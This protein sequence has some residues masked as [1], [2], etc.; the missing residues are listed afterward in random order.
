MPRTNKPPVPIPEGAVLSWTRGSSTDAD[1]QA[2]IDVLDGRV[3][4]RITYL[5]GGHNGIDVIE[6]ELQPCGER[7]WRVPFLDVVIENGRPMSRVQKIEILAPSQEPW[8]AGWAAGEIFKDGD[9]SP[10]LVIRRRLH[11][12][13]GNP[14]GFSNALKLMLRLQPLPEGDPRMDVELTWRVGPN[15]PVDLDTI[16]TAVRD[17]WPVRASGNRPWDGSRYEE[18]ARVKVEDPSDGEGYLW[19][20]VGLTTAIQNSE[21][22]PG[23]TE[24]TVW[25]HDLYGLE[26]QTEIV[27]E[28]P[29]IEEAV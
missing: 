14:V 12:L 3:S 17:G 21:P 25:N 20:H 27:S 19:V 26:A 4:S 29:A 5:Y 15:S 10:Y 18:V 13:S 2:I 8:A 28:R 23:V 7:S 9:V 6:G 16:L 1:L 22:S 24:I 11:Y